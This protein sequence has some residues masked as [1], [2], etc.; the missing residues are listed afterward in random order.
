M[1]KAGKKNASFNSQIC[2]IFWEK[3]TIL[4]VD[5]NPKNLG[6]VVEYLEEFGLTILVSQDGESALKRANFAHPQLILL[7]ILMPGIDGFETCRRLKANPQTKNIPVIFMTALATPEDKIKGFEVGAVDYVTKPIQHQEVW[8]RVKTHLQIYLLNQQLEQ[9]NQLLQQLVAE[10]TA[11]L[12]QALENLQQS[13]LQLVKHEKMSILGQ[14]VAGVAH[15]INNPL[16]FIAGNLQHA[17]EY[18]KDLLKY[19]QSYQHYYPNPVPEMVNLAE[20]I[21]LEYIM[22][23]LPEIIASMKEG[24]D[25]IRAISKSMRTFSRADTAKKVPFNIHEGID[26][27]L[28]I[29]KHRL[30]A[31]QKRSEI[32]IIKSYSQLP[33]IQCYPGQLNQVFMNLIANAI[34]ALEE[35]NEQQCKDQMKYHPHKLYQLFIQTKLNSAK[36]HVIISIKDNGIGITPEVQSRLFEYLYTTKEP[37]KGTGLGL[38]I[39]RQIVQDK[40]GG[41]LTCHSTP[42][43]GTEFVISL[44]IA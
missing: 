2:D 10:R 5:D 38:S 25:R 39:S 16:G 3:Y 32:Q 21:D 14:L 13:Q 24:T 27:T 19:L 1:I 22:E 43:E 29:L 7:D 4:I 8:A 11:E 41:D 12:S 40:H 18:I 20:E 26:S 42:G 36:T 30:K 33:K 44:P 15:E 35:L 31:N 28:I 17:Q 34:D 9:Q 6:F 23:D 37:G